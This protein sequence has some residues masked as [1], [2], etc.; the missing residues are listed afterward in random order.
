MTAPILLFLGNAE[1]QPYLPRLKPLV[2]AATVFVNLAP[3]LTW[4][5]VKLYC[6]KKNITGVLS[7]SRKLLEILSGDSKAS[8]DSY[9]GSYFLRDGI[10]VIFLDPLPQ[11]ISLPYGS[12]VTR[13]YISK[14]AAPELWN[15]WPD[16]TWAIGTPANI[17]SIYEDFSSANFLA[18]DIETTKVNLAITSISYTAVFLVSGT[19]VLK[20]VVLSID[21]EWA[22]AWMRKFN[23]LAPQKILQNGKYDCSYLL[24]YNAPLVNWF[25]DTATA[26]HAWYTELPKDLAYLQAFFLRDGRY[27]KD[28]AGGDEYTR[29]EYNARDTYATAISLLQW[30]RPAPF[31]RI[32]HVGEIKKSIEASI[33]AP[34]P[35]EI[36]E[37]PNTAV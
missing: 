21:S 37:D 24:R 31:E 2:G 15:T 34:V 33:V 3:I 12:F 10:E 6:T 1:D 8:L 26:F 29:L 18:V 27:W 17:E 11:L 5:E 20:S 35:I 28:M 32:D 19:P 22:L 4:A 23:L 7:T 13:R 14:L 16:F 25:A 30:L 36:D 9:A